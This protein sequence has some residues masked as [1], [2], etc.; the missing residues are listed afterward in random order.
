MYIKGRTGYYS[1]FLI[2]ITEFLTVCSTRFNL[3]F[4]P[5]KYFKHYSNQVMYIIPKQTQRTKYRSTY[6]YAMHS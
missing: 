3:A 5:R 1:E 4:I 6:I 2:F